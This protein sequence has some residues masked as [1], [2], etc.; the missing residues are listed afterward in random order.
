[1]KEPKRIV[2]IIVVLSS[3][4]RVGCNTHVCPDLLAFHLDHL[5]LT[6]ASNPKST[7]LRVQTTPLP[8][9]QP[10]QG[11]FFLTQIPRPPPPLPP[12]PLNN[13]TV[14]LVLVIILRTRKITSTRMYIIIRVHRS[15][16]SP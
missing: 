1:M 13:E 8:P 16:H 15:V 12:S 9:P 3:N 6:A 10:P 4:R 11:F 7:Y 14:F 5:L 2:G